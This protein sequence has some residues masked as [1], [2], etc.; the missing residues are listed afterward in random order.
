MY[1]GNN[2]DA[3]YR[4]YK[5]D[6]QKSITIASKTYFKIIYR[7]PYQ[8]NAAFSWMVLVYIPGTFRI[9]DTL[10]DETGNEFTIKSIPMFHFTTIPEWYPTLSPLIIVGK[11]ENIGIYFAKK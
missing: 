9:D 7:C 5:N 4:E 8:S 11:T 10:V 2:E 3:W 1:A 6:P